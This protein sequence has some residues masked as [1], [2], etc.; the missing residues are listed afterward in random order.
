MVS[1]GNDDE[2]QGF[3]IAFLEIVLRVTKIIFLINIYFHFIDKNDIQTIL[4]LLKLSI[5]GKILIE[6]MFF[7]AKI[8]FFNLIFIREK[9]HSHQRLVTRLLAH[10]NWTYWTW[11]QLSSLS[12]KYSSVFITNQKVRVGFIITLN[13]IDLNSFGKQAPPSS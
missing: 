4:L 11:I 3:K 8:I 1:C 2:C 9:R 12:L 6:N 7:I 5:K 10:D 13:F